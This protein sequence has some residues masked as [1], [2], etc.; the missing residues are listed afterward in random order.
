MAH[1][2]PFV[3]LETTLSHHDR[4]VKAKAKENKWLRPIG[5]VA[6]LLVYAVIFIAL[7]VFKPDDI[8]TVP[9]AGLTIADIVKT[10]LWVGVTIWLIK[11]LFNPSEEETARDGWGGL[12]LLIIAT[13]V[14]GGMALM[15]WG[16]RG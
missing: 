16:Q 15:V 12:G 7:W 11:A 6:R 8:T 14:L 13:T 3:E 9:L 5:F 2:D 1:N 4:A 10:L